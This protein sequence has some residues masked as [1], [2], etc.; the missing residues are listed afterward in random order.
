[1]LIKREK[2]NVISNKITEAD[3]DTHKL[4]NIIGKITGKTED[5]PFPEK[6]K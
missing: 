4:Y 5:N 3:K 2:I 1:M 6:H